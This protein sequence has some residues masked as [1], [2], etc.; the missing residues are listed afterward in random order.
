MR[1]SMSSKERNI[2]SS[3]REAKDSTALHF[4]PS[5]L[6]PCTHIPTLCPHLSP[7]TNHAPYLGLHSKPMPR[8]SDSTQELLHLVSAPSHDT[9]LTLHGDRKRL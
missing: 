2:H 5:P 9:E 6:H 3:L 1:S 8:T 7:P 4:P